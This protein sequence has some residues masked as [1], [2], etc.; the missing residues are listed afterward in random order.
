MQV[1]TYNDDMSAASRHGDVLQMC[2]GGSILYIAVFRGIRPDHSFQRKE[3][4]TAHCGSCVFASEM[5]DSCSA[6]VLCSVQTLRNDGRN[7]QKAS[8]AHIEGTAEK[9]HLQAQ[10]FCGSLDEGHRAARTCSRGIFRSIGI[11]HHARETGRKGDFHGCKCGLSRSCFHTAVAVA[12][13][14]FCGSTVF[15]GALP[16]DDGVQDSAVFGKVHERQKK[17]IAAAFGGIYASDADYCGD[18]HCI[19]KTYDGI[20]AQ[21][22]YFYQG[23]R[24]S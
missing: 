11:Q 22:R 7:V 18:T 8:R 15:A 24:V 4:L 10:Y 14:E 9:A 3:F 23:G 1:C 13:A 12:E 20:F 21:Y 2:R 19:H 6:D 16:E 17:R 5:G